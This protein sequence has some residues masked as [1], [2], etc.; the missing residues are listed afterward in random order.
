MLDELHEPISVRILKTELFGQVLKLGLIPKSG[1]DREV[2]NQL[3]QQ[4]G[5]LND[6]QPIDEETGLRALLASG[7]LWQRPDLDLE[8]RR[9]IMSIHQQ[10]VRTSP[11]LKRLDLAEQALIDTLE[12]F[13]HQAELSTTYF[14][15]NLFDH[16]NAK[17]ILVFICCQTAARYQ[18][19]HPEWLFEP[20]EHPEK[21]IPGIWMSQTKRHFNPQAL[22]KIERPTPTRRVFNGTRYI[23]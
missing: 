12:Q 13:C 6:S 21:H 7:L 10:A 23:Q 3:I 1:P 15:L 9:R 22:L 20:Y 16:P 2:T 19:D 17:E 18:Q 4:L 11:L 5:D 14:Q 8:L